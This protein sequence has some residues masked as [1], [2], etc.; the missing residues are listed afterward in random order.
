MANLNAFFPSLIQNEGGFVNHPADPGGATNWGVILANWIKWGRDLDGDGDIDVEDLKKM[1]KDDAY[2]IYKV[3]FWDKI[4]GD[5]IA[6][7]NVANIFFDMY[8]NAPGVAVKMMQRLLSLYF[9]KPVTIDG[10]VGSATIQALNSAD[11]GQVHDAY[12]RLRATYYRYRA[13]QFDSNNPWHLYFKSIGIKSSSEFEVFL[14]GW[15]NRVNHFVDLLKKKI[16]D[17]SLV[18][19]LLSEPC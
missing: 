10:V 12:K 7:Q 5:Q 13:G 15:L 17:G 9:R 18:G 11:A 14:K 6:S 16:L 19:L 1:S 8:V 4:M 3:H 2:Q